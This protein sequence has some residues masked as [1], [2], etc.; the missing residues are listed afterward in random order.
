MAGKRQSRIRSYRSLMALAGVAA[1]LCASPIASI[2]AD[3]SLAQAAGSHN[4]YGQGTDI[5]TDITTQ[6]LLQVP[7]TK[8][9]PGTAPVG[10]DIKNPVANDPD[11]IQRGMQLFNQMNC[12]GCHAPNGVGGMGPA[13]SNSKF[14]YGGSPANIFLTI[15]QGRPAGMPAWGS[16]L[17]PQS[18]W[19]LV[20]YVQSI[21]KEPSDSWG[22]TTSLSAFKIEQVPSE[23]IS[24]AEPWQHTNSFSFGQKPFEKA[25]PGSSAEAPQSGPQGAQKPAQ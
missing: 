8:V 2:M 25:K 6:D 10:P 5:A 13:L 23:F 14:I 18:I 19:D 24:T 11:A 3:Q 7:V 17:P 9:Y 21:S 16:I 4:F 15:Y 22:K 20:A 1:A 12:S